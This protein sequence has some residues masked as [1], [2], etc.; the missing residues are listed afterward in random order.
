MVFLLKDQLKRYLLPLFFLLTKRCEKKKNQKFIV[1]ILILIKIL[2]RSIK[3]VEY[4]GV[5]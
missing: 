5:T 1:E 3:H 2:F 4:T